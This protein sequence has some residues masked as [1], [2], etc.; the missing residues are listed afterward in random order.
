MQGIYPFLKSNKH[1]FCTDR[2]SLPQHDSLNGVVNLSKPK[3]ILIGTEPEKMT[4]LKRTFS[5]LKQMGVNVHVF[6]P[7]TVPR[8]RPRILNGIVRYVMIMIQIILLKADIYH[9]FNIPDVIGLPFRVKRNVLIYDVRSPWFSSV[10]ESAIIGP[11]WKLAGLIERLITKMAFVVLT[12]NYPLAHRAHLWGAKRVI[13]VPNYPPS[14]FGP[15][16][17]R[18][19]M[20]VKIGLGDSQTVLYL[21]RLSLLEGSELLKSIILK[22]TEEI[23]D[24]KFLIVGDG[25]QRRSMEKFM[26]KHS[27]EKQVILT[28]WIQHEDVAD[29]ISVADLC[30]FPREWTTFSDYTTKE[31]ILKI[32][33]YLTLGKPVVAPR[34]G[35]FINAE[36]PIIAVDP[37]EMPEAV[38]KFLKS[39]RE[40]EFFERPT[41]DVSHRRLKIVYS[42]LGAL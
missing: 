7:Y 35:G 38:V 22:T 18:E 36:F 37:S 17:D 13:M 33:E 16:H 11:L 32:G 26:K 2:F 14:D 28:G 25:P 27:L 10:K 9:V 29:Y 42:T 15:T 4:R 6:S 40:V 12:A 21:G 8:G 5:S 1:I 24:V 30:V 20:R 31:N 34:M 23:E 41:W 3:V 19:S 39:P